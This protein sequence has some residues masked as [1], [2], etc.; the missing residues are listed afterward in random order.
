MGRQ[1]L[2]SKIMNTFYKRPQ[3]VHRATCAK[4]NKNSFR[5]CAVLR[6][7]RVSARVQRFKS[8]GGQGSQAESYIHITNRTEV[9]VGNLLLLSGHGSSTHTH[10][11]FVTFKG[12][13]KSTFLQTFGWRRREITARETPSNKTMGK[14]RP[15]QDQERASEI[16]GKEQIRN[17]E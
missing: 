2:L 15:P 6:L 8:R 14:L 16:Q 9:T 4:Q 11:D 10:T 3:R 1:Y 5:Q 13:K 12:T 17:S 7:G